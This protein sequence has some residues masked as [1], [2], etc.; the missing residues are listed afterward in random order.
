MRQRSNWLII[1][2]V[3]DVC[4][5]IGRRLGLTAA[6][7]QIGHLLMYMYFE[8]TMVC[9]RYMSRHI[10]WE[11]RHSSCQESYLE[12]LYFLLSNEWFIP[13]L[14][15]LDRLMPVGSRYNTTKVCYVCVCVCVCVQE[16]TGGV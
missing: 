2:V 16:A 10:M 5:I 9:L 15:F 14:C 8:C 11:F 3:I 13:N 12:V 6:F 4:H 7:Q 1:N